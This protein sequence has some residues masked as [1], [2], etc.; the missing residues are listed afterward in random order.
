MQDRLRLAREFVGVQDP[1]EFLLSWKTPGERYVP[2]AARKAG[3]N[4]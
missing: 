3:E 1:F 2:L 4:L